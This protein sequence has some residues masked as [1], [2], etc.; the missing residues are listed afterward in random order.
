MRIAVVA[1]ASFALA[2][3]AACGSSDSGTGPSGTSSSPIVGNYTLKL[4]DNKPLPGVSPDSSL[5]SGT[6]VVG[7]SGWTQTTIVKYQVGGSQNPNGDTLSMGGNWAV[8]GSEVT[9][10]DFGNSTA[11]TGTF[12]S[13]GITLTTKTATVLGY[14][15]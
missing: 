8:T 6:L 15:R 4:V 7:D 13:T 11:Y 2:S 12:T 5:E 3:L 9:L 10:Y 14:S 1:L